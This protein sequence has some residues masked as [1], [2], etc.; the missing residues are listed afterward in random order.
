M[1]AREYMHLLK[2][3]NYLCKG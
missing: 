2:I 1:Q 3:F